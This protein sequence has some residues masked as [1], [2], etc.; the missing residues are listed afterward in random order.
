MHVVVEPGGS[1]SGSGQELR[2]GF[3]LSLGV[4]NG[5]DGAKY[6]LKLVKMLKVVKIEVFESEWSKTSQKI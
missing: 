4:D 3:G 5:H 6:G 1:G 2:V